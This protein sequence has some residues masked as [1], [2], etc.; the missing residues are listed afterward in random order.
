MTAAPVPGGTS[1]QLTFPGGSLHVADHPGT[2]PAVVAMH[3]F[4]DDSHIYDRLISHLAP[5]RVITFDW[6]GYGRSGRRATQ[7][8]DPP[9]RQRELA[10]VLDGLTLDQVVLI[11]HDSSGPE[12]VD[13]A[14]DH[15]GRVRAVILLN[16]YFGRSPALRFP[17][18]IALMADPAYQALTDA[19]LG[20]EL[21]RLWLL[22]HSAAQMG[23]EPGDPTGLAAVS[24]V[25]QF[26]G[27]D[28]S[29]DALAEIRAWTA[30]LPRALDRQDRR[31]AAGQL[32]TLQVP[33]TVAFGIGD[34]Y[35]NPDL[36]RHLAGLFGHAQ[37]H[38]IEGAGHW[39]QWDQPTA[40][41]GLLTKALAP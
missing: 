4:P 2:E 30:D 1:R 36:A 17:E 25:P 15:P 23:M 22:Q 29:P 19:L 37:L 27:A 10:A 14:L 35:L 6:L 32:A 8:A 9:A 7:A 11:G 5:R 28:A 33:V 34:Q 24:V 13:F 18:M 39:P 21:Q 16:T 20:D 26:F 3:G 38:L 40:V 41:A 31:I 12:A